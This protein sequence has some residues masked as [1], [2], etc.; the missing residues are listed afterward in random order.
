MMKKTFLIFIFALVF[1][2]YSNAQESEGTTKINKRGDMLV[3]DLFHDFWL[4]VPDSVDARAFDQGVNVALTYNFPILTKGFSLAVG[5]GV[6]SHNFYSNS[7]LEKDTNGVSYFSPSAR[8]GKDYVVNKLSTTY[9][10]IPL[11]IRYKSK[12]K[13]RV[14]VGFTVGLR[15]DGHTKYNGDDYLFGTADQLKIKLRPYDNLNRWNFSTNARIGYKWVNVFVSYS[16]SKIFTEN[17][18]PEIQPL[19]VGLSIIPF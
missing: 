10:T 1:V 2:T 17:K 12:S 4:N 16:L 19:S 9:I 15:I 13:F 11:E 18:G 6:T 5:L 14:S 3:V 8:N 7:I